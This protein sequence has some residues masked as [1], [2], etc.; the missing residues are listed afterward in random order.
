MAFVQPRGSPAGSHGA[1]VWCLA[2]EHCP[3][4]SVQTLHTAFILSKGVRLWCP[5]GP[6]EFS[7]LGPSERKLWSAGLYYETLSVT[8]GD[9]WC[10]RKW[11][12]LPLKMPVAVP[13]GHH[14]NTMECKM[15]CSSL[16]LATQ[17]NPK[18][19]QVKFRVCG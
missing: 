3:N 5:R 16:N 2:R 18:M 13:K 14:Q 1:C 15:L 11:G 9:G 12:K 6:E 4:Q 19:A 10:P 8:L 7:R 17:T